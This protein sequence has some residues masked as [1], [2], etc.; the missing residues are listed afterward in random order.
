MVEGVSPVELEGDPICH[1]AHRQ[2]VLVWRPESI[3]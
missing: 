3:S 2:D 1:Y